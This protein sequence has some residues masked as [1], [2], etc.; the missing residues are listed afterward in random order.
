MSKDKLDPPVRSLDV[1]T[2]HGGAVAHYGRELT[3]SVETVES[4]RAVQKGSG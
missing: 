3:G 2:L 4:P 1:R